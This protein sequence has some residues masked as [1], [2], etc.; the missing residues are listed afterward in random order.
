VTIKSINK[1]F[2]EDGGHEWLSFDPEPEFFDPYAAAGTQIVI[3][4]GGHPFRELSRNGPDHGGDF[5][6][7]KHLYEEYHSGIPRYLT[8]PFA[9]YRYRGPQYA[10][11]AVVTPDHFPELHPSDL[12]DLNAYGTT[13][14]AR[15]LPTNP[16]A[17]LA[18][19]IGETGREGIPS[20]PG[21]Q[22]WQQRAASA[23][24][25]GNE[26]LNVEYGWLPLVSDIRKFAKVVKDH[27]SI[28]AKFERNSGRGLRR[29]YYFPKVE[30]TVVSFSSETPQP[31]LI[32]PIYTSAFGEKI[33]TTTI[34]KEVWFSGCFTYLVSPV[35]RR[36]LD[37]GSYLQKANHLLGFRITP[38]TLWNLTPWSW[39]ADWVGNAGDVYHNISAFANDGLVMRYGYIME[40]K[41]HRESYTLSGISYGNVPDMSFSL[42]QSFTT[43]CM[44]RKR[45]TPYG[46]GLNPDV[47]FSTRQQAIT[48]ALGITRGG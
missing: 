14:I 46:F 4:D 26:Y 31:Q 21:I 11:R 15:V 41:L 30:E 32:G 38:E 9:T 22:S 27:E 35:K 40:R 7:K 6:C 10:H 44:T 1:V 12:I 36:K 34:S 47:D 48:A 29:R 5:F 39:A 8:S 42:M 24:S 19:F 18:T 33:H 23:R 13:A 45:A 17:G 25:A 2:R 3:D 37:G 28:L 43:L 20:L 16:V